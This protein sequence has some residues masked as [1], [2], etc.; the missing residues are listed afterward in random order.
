MSEAVG[1]SELE[2]RVLELLGNEKAAA[3]EWIAALDAAKAA[4]A[5]S[6]TREWAGMAQE[7]LAKAGDVAGGIELLKWRAENTP[8]DQM[9]AKDWLRAADVVAG[10]NPHLL[11]LIQEAGF[12]QKLAARECVRRFRLLYGLRPGA[13][14]KTVK[15]REPRYLGD[16]LNAIRIFNEKE[17]DELVLLDIT[18]TAEKS[19][20]LSC[21]LRVC[22]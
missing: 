16:P 6:A 21:W 17:V 9:N 20:W 1:Q 12:G 5:P 13:L 14:V 7:A 22:A 4:G 18:A 8:A 3:G 19:W 15:F 11:A 10:S 2:N